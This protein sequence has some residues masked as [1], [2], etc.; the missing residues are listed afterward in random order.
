MTSQNFCDRFSKFFLWVF[1]LLL[2]V[3]KT[4]ALDFQTIFLAFKTFVMGLKTSIVKFYLKPLYKSK[5]YAIM[6][7]HL[8]SDR[9]FKAA[10]LDSDKSWLYNFALTTKTSQEGSFLR[11]FHTRIENPLGVQKLLPP[12]FTLD[13]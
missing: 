10:S 5:L 7:L 12:C 2:C 11:K 13:K 9:N 4:F 1:Q 8:I 3:F 6:Y